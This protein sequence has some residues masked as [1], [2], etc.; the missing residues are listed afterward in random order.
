VPAAQEDNHA[1]Q[2]R[3]RLGDQGGERRAH[4]PLRRQRSPTEDEKRI[5][6]KIQGDGPERDQQRHAGL[7]DAAHQRLEHGVQENEDDPDAGDAHEAERA[8]VDI[9]RHAQQGQQ[10]RRKQIS[11]GAEHDG[12]G[13]YHHH[14]LR[15]DMVD[16]V[17]AARAHILRREGRAGNRQTGSQSDHQEDKGKADRDRRDRRRTQPADPEGV[18]QLV[19]GLQQVS[20]ND[21]NGEPD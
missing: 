11:G 20:Q 19:S 4:H 17:L 12:G 18:G 2:S 16:H 13:R 5:E 9:G 8:L 14:G 15:R 1:G 6:Q 7:A 10:R 3:Q 21:G